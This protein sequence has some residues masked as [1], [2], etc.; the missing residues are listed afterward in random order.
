MTTLS[1]AFPILYH[2]IVLGLCTYL[3]IRGFTQLFV[4]LFAGGALLELLRSLAFFAMNFAPGGFSANYHY[5]PI[6]SAIGF[7][8]MIVFLGGFVAMTVYLLAPTAPTV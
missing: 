1:L 2:L 5:F 6:I 4:C 8:G 3:F 7:L